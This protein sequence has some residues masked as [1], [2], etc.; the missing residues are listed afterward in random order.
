M[1]NHIPDDV[2]YTYPPKIA[3][4]KRN[5]LH[6]R[7]TTVQHYDNY[8]KKSLGKMAAEKNIDELCTVPL[9]RRIKN[10][11]VGRVAFSKD[12]LVYCKVA[13]CSWI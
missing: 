6:E 2:V 13:H 5:F 11:L 3:G 1:F 8:G 7:V 9:F 4:C 10:R 12:K